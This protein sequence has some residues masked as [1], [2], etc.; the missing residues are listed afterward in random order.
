MRSKPSAMQI[1]PATPA[2]QPFIES[3]RPR[4]AEYA[5]PWWDRARTL[6]RM[7]TLVAQ[8]LADPPPGAYLAIAE[9]EGKPSGF[10]YAVTRNDPLMEQSYA[11]IL[12]IVVGDDGNGVGRALMEAAERWAREAGLPR[13]NLA[14]LT[15]NPARGF[16]EH[17]GY[18]T[19]A[20]L[21]TKVL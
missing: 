11:F 12:E 21:M 14:V 15:T 10:I 5:P 18:G 19:D 1:R 4:L 13:V 20:T 3:I 16:Y 2:D 6:T 17:L 8:A 9:S 7:S